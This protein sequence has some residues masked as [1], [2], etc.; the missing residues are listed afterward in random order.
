MKRL[1]MQYWDSPGTP[2]QLDQSGFKIIAMRQ[3][4][5]PELLAY[6]AGLIDGEGC[7]GIYHRPDRQSFRSTIRVQMCES[8]GINL[9]H[10]I[11]GGTVT[12]VPV[13]RK[14]RDRHRPQYNWCIAAQQAAWCAS[15]LVP[16]LRVKRGQAENLIDL[17]GIQDRIKREA[18]VERA[19]RFRVP[20]KQRSLAGRYCAN[21]DLLAQCA[22]LSAATKALNFR[23]VAA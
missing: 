9:L 22:A 21:L 1:K 6:C 11:F 5:A 19:R 15:L 23:G 3:D 4:I 17:Q 12:P 18:L 2:V 20:N 16:F 7:I 14:N 13:R 10:E 8:G